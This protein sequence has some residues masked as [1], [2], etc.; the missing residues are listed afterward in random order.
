MLPSTGAGPP[1]VLASTQQKS[2]LSLLSE[3]AADAL[4]AQLE[5]GFFLLFFFALNRADVQ[6]HACLLA[7]FTAAKKK[8]NALHP[9]VSPV[10]A[11]GVI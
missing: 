2:S 6:V 11:E 5:L 1:R 10:T 9:F 4:T 7:S 8:K 3:K